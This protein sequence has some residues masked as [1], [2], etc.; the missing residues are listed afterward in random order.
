[1]KVYALKGPSRGW[2]KSLAETQKFLSDSI[3]N[4]ISRFGWGYTNEADLRKIRN[5]KWSDIEKDELECWKKASFLLGINKG[6]WIVHINLPHKGE[7]I[8]GQVSEPY[9]FE[10]KDNELGDF[11][12]LLKLEKDSIIEFKRNDSRVYPQIRSR[13]VLDSVDT[14]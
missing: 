6:D 1:M 3:K 5:M 11:R 12:H 2:K 7:C 13:L 14:R 10:E 9:S 4:G 8:A